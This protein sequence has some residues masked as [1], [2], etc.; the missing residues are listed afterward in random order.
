MDELTLRDQIAMNSPFTLGEAIELVKIKYQE[1]EDKEVK[2]NINVAI[3]YLA[4]LNYAYAD[5][6]LQVRNPNTE[7]DE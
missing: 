4:E 6:M 5:K 3:Q 1:Q 2:V 7:G